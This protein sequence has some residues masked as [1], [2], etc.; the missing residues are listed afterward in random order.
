MTNLLLK[1]ED[2]KKTVKDRAQIQKEVIGKLNSFSLSNNTTSFTSRGT[3][4]TTLMKGMDKQ[5]YINGTLKKIEFIPKEEEEKSSQFCPIYHEKHADDDTAEFSYKSL[6]QSYIAI[7]QYENSPKRRIFSEESSHSTKYWLDSL[8]NLR[9]EDISRGGLNIICSRSEESIGE[10]PR[11]GGSYEQTYFEMKHPNTLFVRKRDLIHK[12]FAYQFNSDKINS[13]REESLEFIYE[14]GTEDVT[15]NRIG[16][17][18]TEDDF[19]LDD[20]TTSVKEELQSKKFFPP[21]QFEVNVMEL[22]L[23]GSIPLDW[24]NVFRCKIPLTSD[25]AYWA[26]ILFGGFASLIDKDEIDDFDETDGNQIDDNDEEKP[27]VLFVPDIEKRISNTNLDIL[28]DRY[29]E[30]QKKT[31][32]IKKHSLIIDQINQIVTEKLN[33]VNTNASEISQMN[34]SPRKI[35]RTILKHPTN[36]IIY[37][38]THSNHKFA[39]N[40]Q[41][42]FYPPQQNKLKYLTGF[43][44]WLRMK[45]HDNLSSHAEDSLTSSFYIRILFA[46]SETKNFIKQCLSLICKFKVNY[47]DGI[48]GSDYQSISLIKSGLIPVFIITIKMIEKAKEFIFYHKL[49]E[50]KIFVIV[51]IFPEEILEE[52][53]LDTLMKFQSIN[54]QIIDVFLVPPIALL[55]S[56]HQITDQLSINFSTNENNN[57]ENEEIDQNIANDLFDKIKLPRSINSEGTKKAVY[58][59][60]IERYI[61]EPPWELVDDLVPTSAVRK[62]ISKIHEWKSSKN[63]NNVLTFPIVKKLSGS[64]ATATLRV[65]SFALRDEFNVLWLKDN[66]QLEDAI[67]ELPNEYAN[68]TSPILFVADDVKDYSNFCDQ[69]KKFWKNEHKNI[70]IVFLIV[71][72]SK[73]DPKDAYIINPFLNS[74]EISFFAQRLIKFY[75]E[76]EKAINRTAEFATVV[77]KPFFDRHLYTLCL[78]ATKGKYEPAVEWVKKTIGQLEIGSK[79]FPEFIAAAFVSAF[80]SNSTPIQITGEKLVIPKPYFDL[81]YIE[82]YSEMNFRISSVHPFIARL[83][84]QETRGLIFIPKM[85][86]QRLINVWKEVAIVLRN[87]VPIEERE[88]LFYQLLVV[89]LD[90]ETYSRLI[91]QIAHRDIQDV[92]Y[93]DN[94]QDLLDQTQ[95]ILREGKSNDIYL[96]KTNHDHY[97]KGHQFVIQSRVCRTL[98]YKTKSRAN[99]KRLVD[100]AVEFAEDALKYFNKHNEQFILMGYSLLGTMLGY[101]YRNFNNQNDLENC[102]KYLIGAYEKS[103]DE[104]SRE[105]I[106]SIGRKWCPDSYPWPQID[107]ISNYFDEEVVK[108]STEEWSYLKHSGEFHFLF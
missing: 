80:C 81:F 6:P 33:W 88:R 93:T 14:I 68:N 41:V 15:G 70:P 62:I 96:L 8:Q 75:P 3:F 86:I 78:A 59:Q 34:F 13:H 4:V 36:D 52:N 40:I 31:L 9:W 44:M 56:N 27:F 73:N 63:R 29:K 2:N 32:E 10:N 66:F 21:L 17:N 92:F 99:L 12:Y 82:E 89:K 94:S 43:A 26:L 61:K 76:N 83:F 79:I 57:G 106:A 69:R 91:R 60:W 85:E 39:N 22:T 54:F 45:S 64:G 28:K 23:K 47:Y 46:T 16:F 74:E 67:N 7:N 100:K 42:P 37:F 107:V 49:T 65:V 25:Q 20:F 104:R 30:S 102:A 95:S 51:L 19:D 5:I 98:S 55:D 103:M 1:W 72:I 38:Q 71:F 84:L 50:I 24:D 90:G 48:M 77:E 53:L 97:L 87:S 101:R 11:L 105:D 108:L 18:Y 58:R 35:I